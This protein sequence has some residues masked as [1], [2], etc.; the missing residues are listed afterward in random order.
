MELA[1]Q[2][3][4]SVNVISLRYIYITRRFVNRSFWGCWPVTALC[5]LTLSLCVEAVIL[6]VVCQRCFKCTFG[7]Y[8]LCL[9][10]PFY[11]GNVLPFKV[12]YFKLKAFQMLI[13]AIQF[14]QSLP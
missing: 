8:G 5:L 12:V 9:L 2:L 7:G 4:R 1:C 11:M 13:N 6:D 10:R 3:I 14:G